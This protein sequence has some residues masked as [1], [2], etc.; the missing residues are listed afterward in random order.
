MSESAKQRAI[1]ITAPHP[2]GVSLDPVEAAGG[3]ALRA[4]QLTVRYG[5]LVAVAELSAVVGP[6][7][8]IAVTGPSGAGKSS[9]LSALAG[10]LWPA[11]GTVTISGHLIE[12]RDDAVAHRIVLIPQGNALVAV[13][14]AA[15]NIGLPLL[16]D[17]ATAAE[18]AELT[19]RVLAAVGMQ[20]SADQLVDELSGGQQQR[21]A[22][23]R[24]LAQ[25]GDVL[26]ADEPTSE[27]DAGNRAVV[28]EL[29]RLE[30]QRGAAVV[31]AT[32]DPEVAEVC[33]AELHL[34]SGVAQWLRDDRNQPRSS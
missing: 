1:G 8:L 33:D 34:D 25:R 13:L 2:A 3:G 6:G 21:V 23:A 10:L 20:D 31:V 32:H 24:G 14:T 28:M 18:A 17:P 12:D 9:A 4:V 30:A 19:E 16:A 27:L 15:E 26:L 29:L 22:V 7:E 11:E 5:D